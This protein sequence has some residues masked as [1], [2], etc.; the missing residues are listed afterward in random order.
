MLTNSKRDVSFKGEMIVSGDAIT[1]NEEAQILDLSTYSILI[2]EDE[3]SCYQYL[4]AALKRTN[5]MLFWAKDG[6]SAIDF[7]QNK[8]KIDLVLMDIKLPKMTGYRATEL[9]KQQFPE[10]PIIAQTA[11]ALHGDRERCLELGFDDYLSKP[12]ST[13]KL[14]SAIQNQLNKIP[15]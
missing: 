14:F 2:V 10:I 8:E 7:M 12:F 13:F 1:V 3:P 9:I 11:Y 4:K 6:Q 15:V 5:A